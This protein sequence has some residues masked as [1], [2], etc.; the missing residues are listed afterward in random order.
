MRAVEDAVAPYHREQLARIADV[1]AQVDGLR[2]ELRHQSNRI[3]DHTIKHEIRARR[4]LVFAGEQE[5]ALQSARFVREFMPTVPHFNHPHATLE[6]ALSLVPDGGM[7]LEFG[8]YT[9]STLKII[10]TARGGEDVYGFDSFE[11]LP[12]D[13]RNGFPAGAF[14]VDGLPD[15]PGAELVVGWFDDTLPGFLEEHEGPVTFLHVDC[16][17]YSSTKTVLGL[18]GPRLVEGSIVLFDEYFNFPGWQQHEYKAWAE[19]VE[20]T[21]LQF[22]YLGYTYDHEQVIVKVTKV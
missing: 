4:D 12:E 16:D 9:G 18:C 3:V 13:W 11:G 19:Y 2:E 8:V 5:A 6:H 1:Q 21:G 22:E 7:A 10:S 14:N 15:V 20:E 17:L